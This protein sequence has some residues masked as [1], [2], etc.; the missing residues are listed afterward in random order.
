MSNILKKFSTLLTNIEYPKEKCSWHIS[1]ILP[2]YSNQMLKFDVRGMKKENEDL[3]SKPGST[4][5][6]ADKIVFETKKNWVIFDSEEFHQYLFDKKI[7]VVHLDDMVK[8]L[9]LVWK[10]NRKDKNDT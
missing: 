6:Q 3:L 10:I 1:G 5:S 8:D 7:H 4:S 2:K 9:F